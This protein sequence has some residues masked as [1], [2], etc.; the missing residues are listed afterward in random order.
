MIIKD[1]YQK[2][3]MKISLCFAKMLDLKKIMLLMLNIKN[4]LENIK[5]II[6]VETEYIIE[7]QRMIKDDEEL[8]DLKIACEI[9]DNC[10]SYILIIYKT[11]N[12]RN[13]NCKRN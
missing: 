6:L 5:L 10:F 8:K 12:D 3:I 2:M 7:K 4:T 13:R 1:V 11:R 9:T